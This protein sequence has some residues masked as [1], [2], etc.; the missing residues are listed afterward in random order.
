MQFDR[1][2]LTA[3]DE[4]VGISNALIASGETGG[5]PYPYLEV[6]M[7]AIQRG[8][9]WNKS[10]I[11]TFFND[12]HE[13]TQKTYANGPGKEGMFL[14]VVILTEYKRIDAN[15]NTY[16]SCEIVDGQQRITSTFILASILIDHLKVLKTQF[17]Q[18]CIKLQANNSLNVAAQQECDATFSSAFQL[19]QGFLFASGSTSPR[20]NTWSELSLLVTDAVYKT[21]CHVDGTG[22][23]KKRDCFGKSKKFAE[24][25]LQ[26]REL[27]ALE[28]DANKGRTIQANPQAQSEIVLK[29]Q[30]EYLKNLGEALLSKAYVVKLWS[31]SPKDGNEAFLSLNSKGQA[32]ATKDI[33]KALLISILPSNQTKK[34]WEDIET[35]VKNVDQFIRILWMIYAGEQ[36]TLQSLAN[37]IGEHLRTPP[38]PGGISNAKAF[39]ERADL[40]SKLYEMIIANNSALS[41]TDFSETQ[42]AMLEN[43]AVNYRIF[44]LRALEIRHNL[45]PQKKSQVPIEKIIEGSAILSFSFQGKFQYPQEVEDL[46]FELAKSSKDLPS[47]LV[48]VSKLQ[49]IAH[50]CCK[51]VELKGIKIGSALG[52]LHFLEEAC[53]KANG[54][55]SLPWKKSNESIEHIAPQSGTPKWKSTMTDPKK[56][57]EELSQQIGNLVILNRKLNS[58]I[59]RSRWVDPKA[60][61]NKKKSKREACRLSNRYIHTQDLALFTDWTPSLVLKRSEWVKNCLIELTN[62]NHTA[63]PIENFSVW[64]TKHP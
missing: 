12:L 1:L 29:N 21:K 28:L 17:D 20:L 35:R 19:L 15:G 22:I 34:T 43:T 11:K 51:K 53:L 10:N 61:A 60:P 8:Y 52:I 46:Y 40:L 13:E 2:K 24:A 18:E 36:R 41:L 32:L 37:N 56:S 38:L 31:D 45:S 63:G 44:L 7:A 14:G 16:Y 49:N 64:L 54:Q 42:L 4:L 33:V 50:E 58:G 5:V 59:Q 62:P 9:E 25:I 55:H 47:L 3:V 27:V 26:L 30:I 6:G 23:D 48:E 39:L 57:Y